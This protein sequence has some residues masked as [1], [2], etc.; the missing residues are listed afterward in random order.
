MTDSVCCAGGRHHHL[1][2]LNGRGLENEIGRDVAALADRDLLRRR[3]I[4]ET[5]HPHRIGARRDV[6]DP[7]R[8]ALIRACTALR[9]RENDARVRNWRVA[10]TLSHAANDGRPLL[11]LGRARADNGATKGR[12][13]PFPQSS[14]RVGLLRGIEESQAL[15]GDRMVRHAMTSAPGDRWRSLAEG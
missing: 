6:G 12:E 5:R 14:H 10:S 8:S 7:E 15:H 1:I 2:N 13:Q 11:G 4:T 3:R 9:A